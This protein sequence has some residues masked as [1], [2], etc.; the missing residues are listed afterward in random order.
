MQAQAALRPTPR[1]ASVASSWAL[2]L[3]PLAMLAG[4]NPVAAAPSF[5]QQTGQPC[6]ACHVGAFGPQ[7]KQHGRDFK[8]N[9]YVA[10]DGLGHGITPVSGSDKARGLIP[11]WR[12]A[13]QRDF[14]RHYV[15]FGGYGLTASVLPGGIDIP[16]RSDRFT[17]TAQAL[18]RIMAR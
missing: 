3:L 9:G 11:Y 13:L 18:Q 14:G 1:P 10:S 5:A 17:D 16:G 12:V 6:A 8:L 4:A 7:L 2:A 15:E